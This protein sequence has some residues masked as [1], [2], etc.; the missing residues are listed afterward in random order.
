MYIKGGD[1]THFDICN[2]IVKINSVTLFWALFYNAEIYDL[3]LKKFHVW[4]AKNP[5]FSEPKMFFWPLHTIH[6]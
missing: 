2:A 5:S 6:P 1:M 4:A 3:C